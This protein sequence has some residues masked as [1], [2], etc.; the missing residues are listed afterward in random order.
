MALTDESGVG[1]A[2]AHATAV[3]ARESAASRISLRLVKIFSVR[4]SC[5][6]PPYVSFRRSSWVRRDSLRRPD[7]V[8]NRV[9]RMKSLSH[10]GWLTASRDRAFQSFKDAQKVQIEIR[11]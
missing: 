5:S 7:A 8:L 1:G 4:A 6:L 3:Q 9:V 11:K 2:A 10:L